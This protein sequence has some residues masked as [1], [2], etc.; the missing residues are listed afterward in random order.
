MRIGFDAKRAFY[1]SRGLGNYSRDLLRILSEQHPEH[2]YLL[3]Y[4]KANNTSLMDPLSNYEEV[5]PKGF[6]CKQNP[7]LWRTF[8]IPREYRRQQLD[9]FHGLSNEIPF[10]FGKS[11]TRTILT[12]HD[13]IFLRFPELYPWI[14]QL[15]YRRKYLSSCHRADKIIAISNQTRQDLIDLVGIDENRISVVHQGCNPIFRKKASEKQLLNV[16]QKYHL[17]ESYILTVGAIEE[18]KNQSLI[19]EALHEGKI[20]QPLVIVGRPVGSW[21]QELQRRIQKMGLTDQVTI[22]KDVTTFDLPAVYQQSSLFVYPSSYE[23]FGIPLLEALSS[24][25]PVISSRGSCLEE[26]GG[27]GSIYID[28]RDA[29][30]LSF[31]IKSTLSDPQQKKKMIKEGFIHAEMFSDKSIADKV[32]EVYSSI[33]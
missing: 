1:N 16:R 12:M 27:P 13:L 10:Q 25:V 6:L 3:F 21:E 8:G 23:G 9:I 19:V 26:A 2:S 22:L 11:N 24:G 33:L 28:H 14:D 4:A 5:G 17:P 29:S 30:A 20:D 15:L 32:I 31:A 18:R 7:S